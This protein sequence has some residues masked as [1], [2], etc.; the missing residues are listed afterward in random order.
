MDNFLRNYLYPIAILS[1]SI[2]GV[3][4]LSLPYIAS[5]VGIL[6]MLF[7]FALLIPLVIFIHSIFGQISLKTPDFKRWPGF[8]GFY[9][10]KWAKGLILIPMILGSFGVLLA[11]LIVGSQFLTAFFSPYLGGSLLMYAILYFAILS[12]IIYFGSKSIPQF[13]L[14]A[15]FLLL[16]SLLLIFIK[17]FHQ[18]NLNNLQVSSFKFQVSSLFLPYGAILF[19]LWGTALIPEAEEMLEGRKQLLKKII[20]ISTLI[21]A[22]IYLLFIF[23]VLGISGSQT[24][25]SALVG[26]RNILGNG[27]AS[28]VLF[29]G[30]LTTFTAFISQGLFLKKVFMYDIGFKEFPAWLVTCFVPLALFL[31]GITS[32]IPLIS[33]VGGVLLSIDGILILLIYKKIGGR[34]ALIYPLI[35]IFILGMVYSIVYFI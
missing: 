8:V 13:S 22:A 9:F 6:V 21:P 34:P 19:S 5:K 12:A 28:T 1:G 32:F 24:T 17:G 27:F 30:V 35:L 20:V 25:E 23:L 15:I 4:F 14:L 10:G 31:L 33:L 11:Y 26:V 29:V 18:I 16:L 7:Y 3:G 2:I